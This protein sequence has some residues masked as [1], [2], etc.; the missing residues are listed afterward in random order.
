MR[1][2]LR[3]LGITLGIVVAILILLAIAGSTYEALARRSALNSHEAPGQLVDVGGHQLHIVC[4]GQDDSETPV[5]ILESGVGGWSMHWREAQNQIAEF[6]QVCAYDRAGMGWSEL[7]PPPRDGRQIANEL[8]TLL[9]N[10]GI[11]APYVLVGASRGGQYVRLYASM[12]PDEVS[13]LVL[14]DAEPEEMRSRSAFAQRAAAQNQGVFSTMGLATRLGVFRLLG[15]YSGEGGGVPEM[16]CLPSMTRHL[17][18]ELRPLYFAVEGQPRCTQAIIAEHA[19][20][21]AREAQVREAESLGDMPL[22]VLTHG[23]S[24]APPGASAIEGAAE[25]EQVWQELQ[26]EMA[27]LSSNSRLIV[28]EESGHNIMVDQPELVVE[29]VRRVIEGNLAE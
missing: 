2:F 4:L 3:R 12:F 22:I 14:V 25:Y 18:A 23:L 27:A 5:V 20:G 11:P 8:H 7:G 28:A 9:G 21:D 13:G 1:T 24:A 19:A 17:P 29:S 6:A 15:A 10:A 26:L 16:P